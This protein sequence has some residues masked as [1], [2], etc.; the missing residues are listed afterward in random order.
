MTKFKF[1]YKIIPVALSTVLALTA[2]GTQSNVTTDSMPT[3]T[4]DLQAT[5]DAAVGGTAT[6][7]VLMDEAINSGVSATLTALPPQ[8]TP[9]P[10]ASSELSQEEMADAV[11]SSAAEAQAASSQCTVAVEQSTSDGTVTADEVAYIQYYVVYTNEEIQQA[12]DLAEEYSS[13]YYDLAEESLSVLQDIESD[14]D[15]LSDN[16]EAINQTLIEISNTLAQG[17]E[18]AQET[19][20]QLNEQAQAAQTKAN[21][22]KTSSE[23]WKAQVQTEI[24]TRGETLA[25]VKPDQNAD[26][27]QS[28]FQMTRDY[29]DTIKLSLRD[30][31]LSKTEL[32][33][34]SRKGANASAGL[35]K[36]GGLETQKLSGS[37]QKLTKEFARG[38]IPQAK[39]N[40]GSFEK[41]LPSLPGFR[42]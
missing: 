32:D 29:I 21:E 35:Q 7:Q 31:K 4:I 27:L 17:E 18:L 23:A 13:L 15:D 37:I 2:C 26:S 28:A 39:L 11:E 40:L 5:I 34:I 19:I 33:T 6:A 16:T 8:S 22:M 10:V 25:N 41:L 20:A 30:G 24:D 1:M 9:T 14:L 3:A 42:N 12:Y 36:F 38:E